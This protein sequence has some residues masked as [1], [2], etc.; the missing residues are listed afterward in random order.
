LIGPRLFDVDIRFSWDNDIW[1][2]K[3]NHE[4]DFTIGIKNINPNVENLS[5][6]VYDV[7]VELGTERILSKDLSKQMMTLV[8]VQ[9]N[10]LVLNSSQSFSYTVNA[11]RPYQNIAQDETV[12]LHYVIDLVGS[13]HCKDASEEGSGPIGGGDAPYFSNDGGIIGGVED[14]VWITI[15]G[16][17]PQFPWTYVAIGI[18]VVVCALTVTT[19]LVIR[20]NR[21]KKKQLPTPPP[22]PL[23]N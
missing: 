21:S 6:S 1:L 22:P 4:I 20:R 12:K 17:Q 8:R 23:A 9:S 5:L 16:V 18:V 14:P 10:T 19:G 13:F 7:Y 15:K 2:L 3:E 11:S